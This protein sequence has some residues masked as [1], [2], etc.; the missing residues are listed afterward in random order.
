MKAAA[1]RSLAPF[2]EES[3]KLGN[4]EAVRDWGHASDYCEAYYRMMDA[5]QA[6]LKSYVVATG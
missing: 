2:S 5:G 1:L 4:L 3:L 6:G